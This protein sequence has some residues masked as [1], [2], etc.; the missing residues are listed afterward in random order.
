MVNWFVSVVDIIYWI[1]ITCRHVCVSYSWL[2]NSCLILIGY[3]FSLLFFVVFFF[4][5]KKKRNNIIHFLRL[6][7]E[8]ACYIFINK[9]YNVSNRHRRK[10]GKHHTSVH[11]VF[12]HIIRNHRIDCIFGFPLTFFD[13]FFVLLRFLW[14]ILVSFIL[15]CCCYF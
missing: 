8:N 3:V 1:F 5:T 9:Q 15:F 10:N 14:N 13:T 2:R 7:Q 12:V 11:W 6:V 4:K